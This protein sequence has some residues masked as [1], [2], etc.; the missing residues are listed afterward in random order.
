MPSVLLSE[1]PIAP[2]LVLQAPS[3]PNILSRSQDAIQTSPADNAFR[4]LTSSRITHCPPR[5]FQRASRSASTHQ[6]LPLG[7]FA[8]RVQ[9]RPP[10]S[11]WSTA[12]SWPRS[13]PLYWSSCGGRCHPNKTFD[14]CSVSNHTPLAHDESFVKRSTR[15]VLWKER[16]FMPCYRNP[17][18]FE[19]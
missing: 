1:W 16:R 6:R 4:V 11:R 17:I 5:S 12:K 9:W 7:T 14:C 10:L 8:E 19:P 3:R 13:V 15:R 18:E 2:L